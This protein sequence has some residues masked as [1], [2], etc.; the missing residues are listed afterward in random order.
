MIKFRLNFAKRTLIIMHY[1]ISEISYF[2]KSVIFKYRVNNACTVYVCTFTVASE[3]IEAL[4][5]RNSPRVLTTSLTLPA[6]FT[7]ADAL[8]STRI[9]PPEKSGI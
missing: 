2:D 1:E 7:A 8:R 3:I 6:R 5:T 4:I 9:R